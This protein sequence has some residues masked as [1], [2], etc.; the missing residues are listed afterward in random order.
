MIEIL[1]I[2]FNPERAQVFSFQP[3]IN[4]V[5]QI[6]FDE[7][8]KIFLTQDEVE[9]DEREQLGNTEALQNSNFSKRVPPKAEASYEARS[10][11][12]TYFNGE[13]FASPMRD[14]F[15]FKLNDE[16]I[17]STR[18]KGVSVEKHFQG[19]GRFSP[20]DGLRHLDLRD[21]KEA[22]SALNISWAERSET[23]A[24]LYRQIEELFAA[25]TITLEMIGK[26][27]YFNSNVNLLQEE[28]QVLELVHRELY[29]N[30]LLSNVEEVFNF[31]NFTKD[32][33]QTS[34]DFQN[35]LINNFRLKGKVSDQNI[36]LLTQRYRVATKDDKQQVFAFRF[37][38]DLAYQHLNIGILDS[39]ASKIIE[40]IIK[41]L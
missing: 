19:F 30:G 20:Q 22:L 7:G 2:F 41:Q 5:K 38:E 11:K 23:T 21:F 31:H 16:I 36:G 17:T 33:C 14:P 4:L 35:M 32:G 15:F 28:A 18:Q 34:S 10:N 27:V 8:L 25:Q 24:S 37:V 13:S 9:V 12:N 26:A 3:F 6:S 1:Q 40:Q 29:A 39:W